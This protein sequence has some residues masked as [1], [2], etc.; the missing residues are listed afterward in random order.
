MRCVI[1]AALCVGALAGGCNKK[2]QDGLPAA[3][4]WQGSSE[5]SSDPT[6]QFAPPPAMAARRNPHGSDLEGDEDDP[7]DPHAD[8]DTPD[9]HAGADVTKLGLA[10][11]DPDRTIDPNQRVTGVITVAPKLKD[12]ARP[13]TAVFLIVKRA[14]A[15]GAPAG[16]PLAVDKLT[17]TKDSLAFEL[18]DAQAMVA[19]TELSG[20]VVVMARY[21]Q[22][23][24]AM[25]KQAGDIT[26]QVHVKIPADNVKLSLDTVIP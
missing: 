21:D 5:G 7:S 10:A 15:D 19:G 11:P 12:K 2:S 6:P 13:G 25:S 20:D 4:D 9:P 18:S 14:G 24:D 22:D 16:S 1:S 23:A 17:W 3:T 8:M 26:G